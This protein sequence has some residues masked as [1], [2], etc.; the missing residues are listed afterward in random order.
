MDSKLLVID[1]A[2]AIVG[3]KGL[4]YAVGRNGPICEY[5]DNRLDAVVAV[6][7]R[8]PTRPSLDMVKEVDPAFQQYARDAIRKLSQQIFVQFPDALW[9][10]DR[11]AVE[12]AELKSVQLATAQRLGF[13]VP[14]TLMTSDPKRAQRFIQSRSA[15]II[16]P[17]GNDGVVLQDESYLLFM[18]KKITPETP[19]DFANMK[20][21]PVILQQAIE[22]RHD[23]RITVVGEQCFTAVVAADAEKD[24]PGNIRDWHV[25]HHVGNL[26]IETYDLPNKIEQQCVNLVHELGCQF[27]A[28]DMIV[29]TQGKY[30]F[31]EDNPSGQWAFVELAT[32]QPIGKAMADLLLSAL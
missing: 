9:V 13:N 25:G 21:G 30:W 15:T 29:D 24:V 28:I 22:P 12:R 26:H 1:P 19:L 20:F 16:K 6:W 18:A 11:F 17:L 23:L 2:P 32:K 14:T 27:G 3:G 31:I 7:D 10:S 8:R 4:T 5:E